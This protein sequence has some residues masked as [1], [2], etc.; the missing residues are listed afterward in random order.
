MDNDQ[1][2]DMVSQNILVIPM[3]KK[4]NNRGKNVT[5]A[6]LRARSAK[7]SEG[8]IR[9]EDDRL[10]QKNGVVSIKSYSSITWEMAIDEI[11]IISCHTREYVTGGGQTRRNGRKEHTASRMQKGSRNPVEKQIKLLH[12][13]NRQT[14]L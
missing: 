13:Q 14:C 10:I 5:N 11:I 6:S 12:Y 2:K 7:T 3:Y 1:K 4:G 8:R 9:Y